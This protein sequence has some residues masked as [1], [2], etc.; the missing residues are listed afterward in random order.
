MGYITEVLFFSPC[1]V[2]GPH[3]T[4]KVVRVTLFPLRGL[5]FTLPLQTLSVLA[6]A[7]GD[8]D[9]SEGT[10]PDFSQLTVQ[11]QQTVTSLA[12]STHTAWGNGLVY[13]YL[14]G[15]NAP[16]RFMLSFNG[17]DTSAVFRQDKGGDGHFE[18]T[19]DG[20]VAI[21]TNKLEKSMSL[22]HK[23]SYSGCNIERAWCYSMTSKDRVPDSGHLQVDTSSCPGH[24]AFLGLAMPLC[25]PLLATSSY[26]NFRSEKDIGTETVFSWRRRA[27]GGRAERA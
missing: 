3:Q 25:R 16:Q 17:D 8:S 19:I 2:P 4:K 15:A 21:T 7:V 9:P 23:G 12:L 24:T 13:C 11:V 26:C 20:A 18:T 14:Y 22:Q 27:R 1:L 5:H 10:P 6:G